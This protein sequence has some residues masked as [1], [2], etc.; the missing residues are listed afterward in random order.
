L[1]IDEEDYDI[2]AKKVFNRG[3]V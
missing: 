2:K 3:K 1:Y